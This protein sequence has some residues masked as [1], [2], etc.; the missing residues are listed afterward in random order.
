[1]AL[2][3]RDKDLPD[4]VTV[5]PARAERIDFFSRGPSVIV[6][7]TDL[8]AGVSLP[9]HR[10]RELFGLTPAEARVTVALFEG[11][12]AQEAAESLGISFHTVRVH[13][14]RIFEK[15]GAHRQ[16]DLVR[17]IMRVVGVTAG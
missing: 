7:I 17:L 5:A 12:T 4:S 14:G 6:H 11:Q 8:E 15:T 10:L 3:A 1:M 9:E 16:T 2:T 13:L